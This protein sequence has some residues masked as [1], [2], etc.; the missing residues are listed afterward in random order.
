MRKGPRSRSPKIPSLGPAAEEV[1]SS[2]PCESPVPGPCLFALKLPALSQRAARSPRRGCHPSSPLRL[3]RWQHVRQQ[4]WGWRS[5]PCAFFLGPLDCVR[6]VAANQ[7]HLQALGFPGQ[8]Q[9]P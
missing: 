4:L 1:S 8:G 6:A 9:A 7:H 3:G 5:D 2:P